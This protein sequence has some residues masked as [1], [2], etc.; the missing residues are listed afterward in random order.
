MGRISFVADNPT[1]I[2]WT[3]IYI[4][5]CYL[6]KSISLKK[7]KKNLGKKKRR[8]DLQLMLPRSLQLFLFSGQLSD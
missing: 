7:K 1:V 3:N 2:V 5:L 4:A 8:T 6:Y